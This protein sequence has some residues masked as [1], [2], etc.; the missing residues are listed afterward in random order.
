MKGLF[1]AAACAAAFTSTAANAEGYVELR[2]G[3]AVSPDLTTESIGL[4]AGYDLD[5]GSS[6]FVGG[7]LTADTN[8]GFDTPVYGLN[9]RVGAK[10]SEDGKLFATAGVARYSYAGYLATPYYAV[11]YSGWDTDVAAGVGYQHKI[12]G[13]TRVS[14]QYQHYFDTQFNRGTIGVGFGF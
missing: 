14:I 13:S 8:A 9:L 4:A 2:S 12:G 10:T 3:L 6:A 1:V 5:L 11:F 7:E